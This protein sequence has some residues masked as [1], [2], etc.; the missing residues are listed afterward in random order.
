VVAIA[1]WPREKAAAEPAAAA[2]V[3]ATKDEEFDL[4]KIIKYVLSE[5][6]LQEDTNHIATSPRRKPSR[7]YSNELLNKEV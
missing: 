4:E 1:A 7:A 3:A 2:P 6:C 5:R